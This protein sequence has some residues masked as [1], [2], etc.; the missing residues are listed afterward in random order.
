MAD[1]FWLSAFLFFK[2]TDERRAFLS[3]LK[4]DYRF[5]CIL[6]IT[7]EDITKAGARFVLLDTDNTLA[8]HGSQEPIPG[9]GEWIGTMRKNGIEPIILSNN[10]RERIEPFAKK[11]GIPYVYKSAKPLK[12]GFAIAC[13]KLGADP[14]ETAV[15][16]D[17]IFTDVMGGKIFGS[18]VFLTEPLGPETNN[19]IK[20]KRIIE[21]FVR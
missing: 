20:F 15:I 13:K 16:G 12:K 4:P 14:K 17:Q 2:K 18:K 19:F 21:K 8:L 5:N 7:P 11:L 3:V 9:I 10:S 1:G 6:D